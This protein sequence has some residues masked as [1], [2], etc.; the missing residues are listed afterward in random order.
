MWYCTMP[1]DAYVNLFEELISYNHGEE[2]M[3]D[4]KTGQITI[5]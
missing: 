2:V 1:P 3:L 5:D 4:R